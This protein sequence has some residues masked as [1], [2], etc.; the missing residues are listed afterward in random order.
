MEE[1]RITRTTCITIRLRTELR[2]KI[3]HYGE[4]LRLRPSSLCTMVLEDSLEDWVKEYAKRIYE[5][6]GIK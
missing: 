2:E 4:L 6:V 1:N 5:D 3:E